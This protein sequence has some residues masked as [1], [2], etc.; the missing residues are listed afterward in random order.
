MVFVTQDFLN[1]TYEFFFNLAPIV[2]RTAIGKV[3][4][5]QAPIETSLPLALPRDRDFRQA[6]RVVRVQ[7]ARDGQMVSQKLS[8]Q[9]VHNR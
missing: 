5:P 9:N 7:A 2:H 8:G 6:A 1:A 4:C 3:A